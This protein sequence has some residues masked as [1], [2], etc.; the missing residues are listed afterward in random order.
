ME[1]SLRACLEPFARTGAIDE[2]VLQYLLG[3]PVP[4]ALLPPASAWAWGPF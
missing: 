4:L 3:R 2:D 1:A